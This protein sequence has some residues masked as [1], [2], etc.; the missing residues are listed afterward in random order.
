MF[1]IF[2]LFSLFSINSFATDKPVFCPEGFN[3]LRY[4]SPL[5]GKEVVICTKRVNGEIIKKE[6][7]KT[8][9]KAKSK[10]QVSNKEIIKNVYSKIFL[11]LVKKSQNRNLGEFIT[12]ECQGNRIDWANLLAGKIQSL[13]LKYWFAKGCSL[14]GSFTAKVGD[15][16]SIKFK[17]RDI[18][19]VNEVD[20]QV[21]ISP[22]LLK[23]RS[24]LVTFEVK[25]MTLKGPNLRA[26]L[27]AIYKIS[28]LLSGRV[29]KN[30]GGEITIRE[31]NGEKLNLIESV[32][33]PV[34]E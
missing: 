4:H 2:L 19:E 9:P 26:R 13:D 31:I 29:S 7:L 17:V 14:D 1:I 6:P 30:F 15:F 27:D 24:M 5:Q 10:N 11:G 12:E 16:F 22:S 21:K 34:D 3:P 18:K 33:V 28:Y 23:S 32:Y 20:F 25:D 8:A